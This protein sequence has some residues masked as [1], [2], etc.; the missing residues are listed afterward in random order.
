MTIVEAIASIFIGYRVK[1]RS[2]APFD[3]HQVFSEFGTNVERMV[4]KGHQRKRRE[5]KSHP[6]RLR[7]A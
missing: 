3:Y 6:R 4:R 7:H 1:R 2:A 5:T